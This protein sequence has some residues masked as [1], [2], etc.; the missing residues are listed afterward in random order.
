MFCREE[1]G[2]ALAH[3][4]IAIEASSQLGFAGFGTFADEF[5]Y[6][7]PPWC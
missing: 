5:G 4:R 1:I 6:D 7:G 3:G 2:I